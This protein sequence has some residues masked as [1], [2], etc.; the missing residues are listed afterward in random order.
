MGFSTRLEKRQRVL[1][2]ALVLYQ[3]LLL[4][5]IRSD[6]LFFLHNTNVL[7]PPG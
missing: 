7:S 4:P 2:A 3:P 5:R 1:D 6:I